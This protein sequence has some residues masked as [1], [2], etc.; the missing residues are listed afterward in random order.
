M[1]SLY[2]STVYAYERPDMTRHARHST[3]QL[4][5]Y[6]VVTLTAFLIHT[7][8][9]HTFTFTHSLTT[10]QQNSYLVSLNKK[11]IVGLEGEQ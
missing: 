3:D 6:T 4:D 11:A 7:F 10:T 8:T 2:L 1:Y 5:M 9:H